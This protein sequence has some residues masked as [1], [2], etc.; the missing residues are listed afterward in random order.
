[1]LARSKPPYEVHV[2]AA[3]NGRDNGCSN[4]AAPEQG[5]T[6]VQQGEE[7]AATSADDDAA[8]VVRDPMLL[9]H[10][11]QEPGRYG[12]HS[13]SGPEPR[14]GGRLLE[15][16][17]HRRSHSEGCRDGAVP[18]WEAEMGSGIAEVVEAALVRLGGMVVDR[19]R[20]RA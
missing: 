20:P 3:R 5:T 7:N 10:H 1:M 15:G 17:G 6:L 9:R 18:R 16:G 8:Q 11:A 12:E 2:H 14:R 4:C 19:E 13:R